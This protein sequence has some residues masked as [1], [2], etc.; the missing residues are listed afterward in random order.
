MVYGS[1]G[2]SVWTSCPELLDDSSESEV[3]QRDLSIASLTHI[4]LPLRD[5]LVALTGRQMIMI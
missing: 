4:G 5:I 1:K 3:E 2:A